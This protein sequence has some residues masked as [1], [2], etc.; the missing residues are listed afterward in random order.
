MDENKLPTISELWDFSNPEATEQK[1]RDLLPKATIQHPAYGLEISTQIARTLGLQ[2]KFDQALELLESIQKEITEIGSLPAIRFHLEKGRVYN[3]DNKQQLAL[4]EFQKALALATEN[5]EDYLAID[6][7]HMLGIADAPAKQLDWNLLALKLAENTKNEKAA[8]WK[9]SLYNNI[10]WTYQGQNNF[11]EAAQYFQKAFEYWQSKKNT[12]R[13]FIANWCIARNLRSQ[14]Q[15]P[16]ALTILHQLLEEIN[17]GAKP[18]GYVYEELAECF[19]LQGD[20]QQAKPHFKKAHDLLSKD[21]WLQ[22]NE[23]TRLE[24]LQTLSLD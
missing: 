22:A 16:Q 19:L 18:D 23:K 20:P 11:P 6:A 21:P 10:G 4:P 12:S 9:G 14:N 3:S 13:T 2:R 15:L 1:F 5:N 24:R 17:N 8:N 7:A